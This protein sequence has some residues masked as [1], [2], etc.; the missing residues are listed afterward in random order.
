[1]YEF[2]L[3]KFPLVYIKLIGKIENDNDFKSFTQ[4]WENLYNYNEN[5]IMIFDTSEI[6]SVN[7]KYCFLLSYFIKK[8]KKKDP[9]HLL[10]SLIYTPSSYI[11]KL[12]R[13]IFY[14]TSPIAPVYIIKNNEDS[15]INNLLTKIETID[16]NDDKDIL[17]I[18]RKNL[19]IHYYVVSFIFI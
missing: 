19:L 13:F 6:G 8:L 17:T 5:F 10:F 4:E 15:Y 2:D 3:T 9:Q 18:H 12:L 11:E 14:L 1:M 16:Y 7:I